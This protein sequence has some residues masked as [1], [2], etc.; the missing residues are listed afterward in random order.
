MALF[1]NCCTR[2]VLTT[3][4]EAIATLLEIIN[5][6]TQDFKAIPNISDRLATTYHQKIEDIKDW[7]SLTEWSQEKIDLDLLE[8]IQRQL[9]E[10]QIIDFVVPAS[11][12][13]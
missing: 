1:C 9:L 5:T 2:E 6:K 13:V 3:Q 11:E 4:P 8:G 7:L 12:I 10:M